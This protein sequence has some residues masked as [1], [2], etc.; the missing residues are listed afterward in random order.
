MA[1]N[2]NPNN[3][4]GTYPVAGQ[5]ND[6]QGFRNNFT[7]II[8]NFSTAA[9]EISD[10]Q[11]K[12]ILSSALT[13]VPSSGQNQMGGATINNFT[14]NQSAYALNSLGTVTGTVTLDI[15]TGNYQAVTTGSSLVLGFASTWPAAGKFGNIIL[16]LTV[17]NTAYTLTVPT[18]TPGVTLGLNN[19]V[20]A[21]TSTGVITFSQTGT[22]EF[23]FST[24]DNGSNIMIRDLTRNYNNVAGPLSISGNLVIS[25]SY[26]PTHNTSL[27]SA[28][29]ITF[30]SS[31]LYVC[32]AANTWVRTSI[33]GT[34]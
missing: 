30:D 11:S 18:T 22:Y 14:I 7:N 2:I 31:Y 25:G 23:E 10:L 21:N 33:T 19:I 17:T 6:S 9:A 26:V 29:Q 24:I 34:W 1:S 28:G 4:D 3:I 13:T 15:S 5:D 32:I 12:A 20:N 8:N 16:R 27:G